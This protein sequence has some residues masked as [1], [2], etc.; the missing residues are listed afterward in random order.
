MIICGYYFQMLLTYKPDANVFKFGAILQHLDCNIICTTVDV[1]K[2]CHGLIELQNLKFQIVYH[3]FADQTCSYGDEAGARE[4]TMSL[5]RYTTKYGACDEV[6]WC[7]LIH[8]SA[9]CLP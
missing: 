2:P 4:V 7:G 5:R 6:G 3:S 8:S 1:G 9:V